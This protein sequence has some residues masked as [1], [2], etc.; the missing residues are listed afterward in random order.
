MTNIQEVLIP[1]IGDF[2]SI[3]VIEVLVSPGD[4]IKKEDL[5]VTLESDKATMDIPAPQSGT[6]KEIRIQAGDQVSE[7]TLVLLLEVGQAAAVEESKETAPQEEIKVQEPVTP[8]PVVEVAA[9]APQSSGVETLQ[10]V[11][12]PDIGDFDSIDVIEV[13]VSEGDTVKKEDLI[14]TLESDK[15]TMDIPAPF[16][17]KVEEVKIQA[18][19]QVSEGSLVLMM[20]VA[21]QAEAQKV[22]APKAPQKV[23]TEE[24]VTLA[25]AV[26]A[27]PVAV[28]KGTVTEAIEQITTSK[29]HAGPAVRKFARELGVDLQ[30]VLGTGKNGRILNEDIHAFV[31]KTLTRKETVVVK[32]SGGLDIIDMPIV[33]FGKFGDIEAV[34]LS[35]IQ[36]IAGKN[37]HRNWVQIPHVTQF[38]EADITDLEA[39]RKQQKPIAAKQDIN[40]TFLPLLMK[41]CVS[42][43]KAFPTLNASLDPG[44]EKLILKKYFHIG[45]A[46][47]TPAGLVVVVIKDVDKKSLL[48]I[49]KN[50]QELSG[51]ARAGKIS[52]ADLRGGCFTIS[53]L[54]GIGGTGFTPIINAPE[55]AIMGVSR[56]SMKPVYQ[57]GEFVARL[58]MP[59]SLSYDHRVIDGATAVRFT[60]HLRNNLEDIRRILL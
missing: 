49:A 4:Q 50:L 57:D 55:V 58:V 43:L 33:D 42:S 51:K 1:D 20:R 48:E 27:P 9:P 12:I 38:D 60:T 52:P 44:G 7:G 18:G 39:F 2:D 37:L 40:F 26:E 23:V 41:A 8:A 46:V 24:K 16:S 15:A 59:Y 11:L 34:P 6:V 14:V 47:D 56:S 5:L 31:K 21:G 53:S 28:G 22:E 3:D 29:A 13:L 30:K 35:R 17:G 54:G 10:E 45:V 32:S 25:A 36:K 19:D